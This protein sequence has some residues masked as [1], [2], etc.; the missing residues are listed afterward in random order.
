ML[1]NA[2]MQNFLL[3]T[4][5]MIKKIKNLKVHIDEQSIIVNVINALPERYMQI[6]MLLINDTTITTYEQLKQ[7]L[8]AQVTRISALNPSSEAFKQ[9]PVLQVSS[10]TPDISA[11]SSSS[12]AS[13]SSAGNVSSVYHARRPQTPGRHGGHAAGATGGYTRAQGRPTFIQYARG[14]ASTRAKRRAQ[15]NA[16]PRFQRRNFNN[17]QP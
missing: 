5:V 14:R 15:W 3:S 7:K 10:S 1:N 13:S 11:F 16:T 12:S 4:D 8:L 17:Q 2:T 6:K 9:K